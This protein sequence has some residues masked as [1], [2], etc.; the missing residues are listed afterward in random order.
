MRG[1]DANE[2]LAAQPGLL[3]QVFGAYYKPKVFIVSPRIVS[4]C[5]SRRQEAIQGASGSVR[6]L[7]RA[8][9][10]KDYKILKTWAQLATRSPF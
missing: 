9:F 2:A 3:G 1:K 8:L 6:E 7:E 5:L 4:S 10:S